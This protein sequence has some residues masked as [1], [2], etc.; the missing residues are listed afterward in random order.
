MRALLVTPGSPSGMALRD[1]ADPVAGSGQVLVRISHASLNFG[2]AH[3]AGSP[4]AAADT[5]FGWDAAGVVVAP[6]RDDFGPTTGT[7]VVT[8]GYGG[9][10]AQRRAVDTDELAVI[11]DTV[12]SATA[13]ALPVAGVTALRAL[14][15]SGP[16]LGR[17]VLITGASGGVGRFAIQLAALAGARV[18]AS[19]QRAD[20]LAELGAHE[21]IPDLDDAD[22][23]DVVLDNVGGGQL[24]QAWGL[25]TPG[26]VI[27]SI[28]WTSGEPAAFPPYSTVGPS[29]SLTAF[30]AGTGF[31]TDMAYLL[32]L[33][34]DGRLTVD[35]GWRGSWQRFDEAAAALLG[36]RVTGKAVLDID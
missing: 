33:V 17:R 13:A 35:I 31:G 22:E 11:P 7:R 8:F 2:E 4:E 1:T 10:W 23:I 25:L 21:V 26:G 27:Q 16:L 34:A 3:T 19:A 30:M 5:A 15:A 20:G 36:R 28:G 18:V 6:A 9:A 24:V 29:K 14:R 32:D 12:D